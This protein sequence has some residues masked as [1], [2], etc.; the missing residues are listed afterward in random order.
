MVKLANA[1]QLN[2]ILLIVL[3]WLNSIS[4]GH[5]TDR[6]ALKQGL[7][8]CLFIAVAQVD[9]GIVFLRFVTSHTVALITYQLSRSQRSVKLPARPYSY[10]A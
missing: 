2:R 7:E 6:L 4:I 3:T 5:K 1:V 10:K 8:I 9:K